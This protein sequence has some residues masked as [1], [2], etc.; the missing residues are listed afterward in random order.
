MITRNKLLSQAVDDCMKELYS[1]VQP[2][3]DWDDFVEQNR[4]YSKKYKAWERYYE[5]SK[6][7]SLTEEELKK[8][9][10]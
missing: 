10:V 4:I 2:S 9:S 3:V 5:L 8:F 6:K 1:L 7:E